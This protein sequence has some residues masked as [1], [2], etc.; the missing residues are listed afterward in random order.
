MEGSREK[1]GDINVR[2]VEMSFAYGRHVLG[3][4]GRNTAPFLDFI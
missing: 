2:N 3:Q 1:H 4:T